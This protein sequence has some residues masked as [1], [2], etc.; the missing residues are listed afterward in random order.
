MN[1]FDSSAVLALVFNEPGTELATRLMDADDALIS[2]VNQAEVLGK[3][4]DTGMPAEEAALLWRQLPLKVLPFTAE[5]AQL[6]GQLRPVTRALGLSL[7]DCCCLALAQAT[8]GAKV[9]TA[10][11]PWAGLHGFDIQLI[12]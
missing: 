7:G 4:H 5:H 3:L 9:V 1:V 6:A 2:S 12:R 11:R 8:P 10:D